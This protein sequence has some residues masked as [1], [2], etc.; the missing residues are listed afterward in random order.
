[1]KINTT[2]VNPP[3]GD[4]SCDWEAVTD[5]YED[6]CPIGRGRTED[7]AIEDLMGQV[8]VCPK[9]GANDYTEFHVHPDVG[10]PTNKYCECSHCWT[11]F[12][13]IE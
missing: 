9:C 11:E 3:I 8:N 7:E 5:D 2:F 6:G 13:V 1:M 12:K 4:R 10:D